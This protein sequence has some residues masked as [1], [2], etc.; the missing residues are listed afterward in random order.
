MNLFEDKTGTWGRELDT[1]RTNKK[2]VITTKNDETIVFV[3]EQGKALASDEIKNC[4]ISLVLVKVQFWQKKANKI[5][6][7]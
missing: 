2:K 5:L 7:Y 1:Q 6:I 4:H 3:L